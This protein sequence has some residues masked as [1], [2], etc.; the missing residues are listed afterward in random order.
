MAVDTIRIES[1]Q[2]NLKYC[3]NKLVEVLKYL[4]RSKKILDTSRTL[5]KDFSNN[6]FYKNDKKILKLL[7]NFQLGL[8]KL[9]KEIHERFFIY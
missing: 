9:D 3:E 2:Q 6:N 4:P 7:D 1:F 5:L 8:I